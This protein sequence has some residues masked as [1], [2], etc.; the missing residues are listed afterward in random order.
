MTFRLKLALAASIMLALLAVVGALVVGT[1][2]F[3]GTVT[4]NP[5]ETGL[6]WD[7]IQHQKEALGWNPVVEKAR[8]AVGLNR[9]RFSIRDA[10]GAPV[11]LEDFIVEAGRTDNSSFDQP[12]SSCRREG[13]GYSCEVAFT[14]TGRWEI[15]FRW[16]RDPGRIF[17]VRHVMVTA[18][19]PEAGG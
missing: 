9:I 12:G 16:S 17:F 5:Y 19:P 11:P 18:A 10:G 3:D 8:Y 14:S 7:E 2:T 15:R 4:E 1:L 6:Q 13:N